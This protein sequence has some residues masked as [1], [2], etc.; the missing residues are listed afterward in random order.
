MKDYIQP[1]E[2]HLAIAELASLA[3]VQPKPTQLDNKTEFHVSSKVHPDELAA[4]LAYWECVQDSKLR[5]TYQVLAEATVN[6]VRKGISLDQLALEVPFKGIP[7]IPNRRCLRYGTHG[8]HEYRGKFFPQLVRS[9]INISNVPNGGI[10]ADPMCGSGTTIVE[11][12]LAQCQG[13]G[14]DM[15]PLSVFMSNAKCELLCIQPEILSHE[16]QQL[17]D[18]LLRVQTQRDLGRSSYLRSLPLAD[19]DYLTKWFSLQIL[20]D[21]DVI[22]TAINCMGNASVKN[23]ARLAL[24]N[25]LRKISWQKDDDLRVRRI[26][27]Q[28][29]DLDPLKEYLQELGRSVRLILAF[30]YQNRSKQRGSF[31]ITHGDAKAPGPDWTKYFGLVDAVIT[32]PPYAT[33]LPYLDTD[34]LSLCYL[35]LLSRPEHRQRDLDMI[36]NREITDKGRRNYWEVYMDKKRLLPKSATSLIER[37]EHLN[38]TSDVGFRRKNLGALL[39][40]YFFDMREVLLGIRSLLAKGRYAYIVVGNNRTEAGGK[41]IEINTSV[42]LSDIAVS[43]GLRQCES[44]PMEML[45]SRDIFR[46]NAMPSEVIL[47][48]KRTN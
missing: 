45:V 15:N 1:F 8:I 22:M 9:L 20:C 48:F 5:S 36:G 41:P 42:L 43:V 34:R 4:K 40:K 21:L 18:E 17:R 12:M 33:A 3:G 29:D 47:S 6:V 39:S 13:I 28:E 44:I 46:K 26:A 30:L 23:L 16:Y 7:P 24:S 31:E 11:S 35:G 14:L 37:I 2:R 19:Q 32:S 27:K 25:V 38:S 10:V